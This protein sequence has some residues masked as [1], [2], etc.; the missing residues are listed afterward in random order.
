MANISLN[1]NPH[2]LE[3]T[4]PIT[5]SFDILNNVIITRQKYSPRIAALAQHKYAMVGT[6]KEVFSPKESMIHNC[7]FLTAIL[8]EEEIEPTD[9][10]AQLILSDSIRRA[11]HQVLEQGTSVNDILIK[12]A[13]NNELSFNEDTGYSKDYLLDIAQINIR[14]AKWVLS[15]IHKAHLIEEL[16]G[17]FKAALDILTS[18]SMKHSLS[19]DS[20]FIDYY[21]ANVFVQPMDY[22]SEINNLY[23][24]IQQYSD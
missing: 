22:D 13:Y 23:K 20:C 12:Q 8:Y 21:L 15:Q 14:E 10:F 24:D 2:R 9:E 18:T 4:L 16:I 17:E 6:F 1:P 19:D 11:F 3:F 5:A 7:I